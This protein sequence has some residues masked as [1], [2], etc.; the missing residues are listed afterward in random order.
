[1]FSEVTMTVSGPAYSFFFTALLPLIAGKMMQQ[2]G[3]NYALGERWEFETLFGLLILFAPML[4]AFLVTVSAL[5]QTP[6]Q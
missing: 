1:M 3:V 4:G 2:G 5:S 6:Q